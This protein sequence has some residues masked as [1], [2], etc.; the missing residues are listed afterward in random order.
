MLNSP[1]FIS[2][3]RWGASYGGPGGVWN[4]GRVAPAANTIQAALQAL[5]L[6]AAAMAAG[7][8][9]QLLPANNAG[10]DLDYIPGPTRLACNVPNPLFASP[11][12]QATGGAGANGQTQLGPLRCAFNAVWPVLA[13]PAYAIIDSDAA[14]HMSLLLAERAFAAVPAGHAKIVINFDAHTDWS[15]VVNAMSLRC[16]NWGTHTVR[17]VPG[18]YAAPVADAYVMIGNRAGGGLAPVPAF[19]NTTCRFR[20]PVPAAAQPVAGAGI[21]AQMQTLIGMVNAALNGGVAMP[22]YSVYLTVDRDFQETSFTDY[23]DG[24]YPVANGWQTV[25]DCIDELAHNIAAGPVTFRGF[26]ICGLPTWAGGS[27]AAGGGLMPAAKLALACT[28]IQ[29]LLTDIHAV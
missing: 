21:R 2:M 19:S 14:H 22:G 28:D 10:D 3:T 16:D 7:P 4:A 17:V 26:D 12:G 20:P 18:V 29:R 24:P 9:P 27:V 25:D 13:H 15:G 23:G 6:G 11:V 5:A 8:L 1:I